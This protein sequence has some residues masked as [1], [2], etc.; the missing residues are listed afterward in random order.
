VRSAGRSTILAIPQEW[1]DHPNS[2]RSYPPCSSF[3]E[4]LPLFRAVESDGGGD[5]WHGGDGPIPVVRTLRD[6]LEPWP[7]APVRR[8]RLPARRGD[9]HRAPGKP[10][11]RTGAVYERIR[12]RGPA[13]PGSDAAV[14]WR[15]PGPDRPG[16]P[17]GPRGTGRRGYTASGRR[18]RG[19]GAFRRRCHRDRPADA[20]GHRPLSAGW[21]S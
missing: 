21:A 5:E 8:P 2:A 1:I 14:A 16:A 19:A 13:G 11:P 7:R 4:L 15:R 3:A 9:R 12:P 10:R 18:A 20:S 6:A 17:A